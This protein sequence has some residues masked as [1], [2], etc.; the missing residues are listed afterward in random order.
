M[1][2]GI[3]QARIESDRE[4]FGG[5]LTPLGNGGFLGRGQLPGA[6]SG[7]ELV[8]AIDGMIGDMGYVQQRQF[9]VGPS[10]DAVDLPPCCSKEVEKPHFPSLPLGKILSVPLGQ[11]AIRIWLKDCGK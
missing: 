4:L 7:Q 10:P 5:V 2:V 6:M 11:C 8:N 1:T 9:Y 3:C